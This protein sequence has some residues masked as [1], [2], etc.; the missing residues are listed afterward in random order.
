MTAK[1]VEC[2]TP[3]DEVPFKECAA[4]KAYA[5][6]D[7]LPVSDTVRILRVLE[8]VGPRHALERVL[9]QNAV[10][11]SRRFGSITIREATIGDWPEVL[12][13]AHRSD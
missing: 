10:K 12:N 5:E 11:G 6:L 1:C 8:Y 3:L 13:G 4:H 2:G 9:E 7:P